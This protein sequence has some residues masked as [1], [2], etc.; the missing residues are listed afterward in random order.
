[1]NLGPFL[2]E[3]L[4]DNETVIIPGF[5]AFI[6]NYKPAEINRETGEIVPPSKEIVF[7]QNVRNN[8]GLL[9]GYVSK[10]QSV[11]HFDA[12][13][14]IEKERENIIYQLD[15]GEKIVLEEIGYLLRNERDEIDFEAAIHENLL[16]DSF[17]LESIFFE[18]EEEAEI[19]YA[20]ET[21]E[22]QEEEERKVE[23]DVSEQNKIV[24]SDDEESIDESETED[25]K[26]VDPVIAGE[27]V[28]EK[29]IESTF[30]E[31]DES[32][33]NEFAE[34]REEATDQ[35]PPDVETVAQ[36]QKVDETIEKEKIEEAEPEAEEELVL[37]DQ[38]EEKRKKRSWLWFL[39]IF[40][41]LIGA[42]LYLS[43][44]K[45]FPD[46]SYKIVL[47]EDTAENTSQLEE[48]VPPLDTAVKDSTQEKLVD[49]VDSSLTES[50]PTEV[51][52]TG[53]SKFYLVGGSFKEQENVDKF[54][55]Q[56]DAEGYEPFLLGKRGNFFIVAIAAYPTERE[57]VLARDT[58]MEKN[59]DS[60]IWVFEDKSE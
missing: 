19:V 48:S 52:D 40:V 38:P 42:G 34:N 53:E 32:D 14:I 12:L 50:V 45:L 54:M 33:E 26:T 59:P 41:P 16:L 27:E 13:R 25:E 51:A 3:L 4:L 23:S 6:S 15:K 36:D 7:N 18:E 57:A 39:L 11:S 37:E 60:G 5:G 20:S 46:K 58:F 2:Y 31:P 17:G 44:D 9:V 47:Q 10:K 30:T 43:K 29:E 22:I 56:F 8:D 28:E 55:E 21:A 49:S 24:G 1:M 35:N